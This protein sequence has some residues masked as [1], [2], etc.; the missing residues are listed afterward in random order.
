[1]LSVRA[2]AGLAAAS[3]LLSNGEPDIP[4]EP[5][6]LVMPVV[7]GTHLRGLGEPAARLAKLVSQLSGGALELEF[8]EE[9]G[10][11]TSDLRAG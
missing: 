10:D 4:A 5:T 9:P 7:Y 6:R 11:G 2:A 3:L 8:K 1:M